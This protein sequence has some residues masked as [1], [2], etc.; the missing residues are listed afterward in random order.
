MILV[1]DGTSNL[2]ELKERVSHIYLRRV[3][4][5]LEGMV[6]KNIHEIYYSLNSP[7]TYEQLFI[8]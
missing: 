6:K 4:E 2:D 8:C 3:K 1:P 7:Q 5:D